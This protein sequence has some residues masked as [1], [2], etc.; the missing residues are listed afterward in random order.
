MLELLDPILLEMLKALAVVCDKVSQET[1]SQSKGT[2]ST[3]SGWLWARGR[4][5]QVGC[6]LMVLLSLLVHS[7]QQ[8]RNKRQ[9]LCQTTVPESDWGNKVVVGGF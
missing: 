6:L 5:C 1:Q 9:K 7:Q 2:Y 8:E 4:G 3:T